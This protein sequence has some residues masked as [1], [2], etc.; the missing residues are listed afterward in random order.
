[1]AA[2]VLEN[3]KISS[4]D[5]EITGLFDEVVEAIRTIVTDYHPLGYGTGVVRMRHS[6]TG[7]DGP[8]KAIV[9]RANSCE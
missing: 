7:D 4:T 3:C 8:W 2:T 9:S 6:G 5:Y 1:M